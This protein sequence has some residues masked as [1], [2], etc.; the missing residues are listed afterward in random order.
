[1]LAELDAKTARHADA[2]TTNLL[3]RIQERQQQLQRAVFRT[4]EAPIF[5][6]SGVARLTNWLATVEG[7][8]VTFSET[9]SAGEPSLEV[10]ISS[11]GKA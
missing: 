11:S 10:R 9:N 7:G 3:Y 6:Q 5:D 1:M 4:A 2:A 8:R